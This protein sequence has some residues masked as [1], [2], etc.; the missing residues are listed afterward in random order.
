MPDSPDDERG[1]DSSSQPAGQRNAPEAKPYPLLLESGLLLTAWGIRSDTVLVF[2]GGLSPRQITE[3]NGQPVQILACYENTTAIDQWQPLTALV[4]P[5][6]ALPVTA[7]AYPPGFHQ[8]L[9]DGE[10]ALPPW[11]V[12]FPFLPG[13]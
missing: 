8:L 7:Q 2:A 10:V 3:F 5:D 6:G 13:C 12:L 11:C 4:L 1:S 9:G